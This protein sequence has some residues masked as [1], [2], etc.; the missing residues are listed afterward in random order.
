MILQQFLLLPTLSIMKL[1]SLMRN[2]KLCSKTFQ[3]NKCCT[4]IQISCFK[5]QQ[6]KRKL[7]ITPLPRNIQ[8]QIQLL[9]RRLMRIKMIQVP[10]NSL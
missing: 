9:L 7:M 5:T 4:K 10:M 1:I 6:T 3:N 2:G 8:A